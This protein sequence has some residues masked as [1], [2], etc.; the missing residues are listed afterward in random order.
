MNQIITKQPSLMPPETAMAIPRGMYI[1]IDQKYYEPKEAAVFS[2]RSIKP[3]GENVN[4]KSDFVKQSAPLSLQ[5]GSLA[6][7]YGS[8][9]YQQKTGTDAAHPQGNEKVQVATFV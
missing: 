9:I 2:N 3:H 4:L 5:T 8:Y 7:N 1:D 6:V